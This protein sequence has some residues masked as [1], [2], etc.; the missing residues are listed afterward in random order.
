MESLMRSD[1]RRCCSHGDRAKIKGFFEIITVKARYE[2][3]MSAQHGF[4]WKVYDAVL[5]HAKADGGRERRGRETWCF[6]CR[7]PESA[8]FS[9]TGFL[10]IH[11]IQLLEP[12]C[13][14]VFLSASHC[15]CQ[16]LVL[17][18]CLW[19]VFQPAGMSPAT[20]FLTVYNLIIVSDG[21]LFH[22]VKMTG[23]NWREDYHYIIMSFSA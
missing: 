17:F 8:I 11:Y 18:S 19:R 2:N 4:L 13:R 16:P 21:S 1:T 9:S 23:Q 22:G 5:S 10:F 12:H 15:R 20:S 6:L 7:A 14:R 3:Q